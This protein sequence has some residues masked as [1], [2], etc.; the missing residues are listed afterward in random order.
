[1]IINDTNVVGN[2]LVH[3]WGK[4]LRDESGR[5]TVNGQL[6]K[7]ITLQYVRMATTNNAYNTPQS[8]IRQ[9]IDFHSPGTRRFGNT[10]MSGGYFNQMAS[11]RN[12]NGGGLGEP[13]GNNTNSNDRR[14]NGKEEGDDKRRREFMLVKSSNISITLFIG[15]NLSRNP[16]IPFNKSIR[17]LAFNPRMRRRRVI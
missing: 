12:G 3:N 7:A 2:V 4:L 14:Y 6:G 1:M 11:N 5:D 15:F 17:Q 13:D 10:S 16:Y 8:K 9:T